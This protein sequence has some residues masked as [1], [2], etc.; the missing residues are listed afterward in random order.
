MIL[1]IFDFLVGQRPGEKEEGKEEEY[2][3]LLSIFF[4]CDTIVFIVVRRHA[5]WNRAGW[6]DQRRAPTT[7][8]RKRPLDGNPYLIETYWKDVNHFLFHFNFYLRRYQNFWYLLCL[9]FFFNTSS[10]CFARLYPRR[11][12]LVFSLTTCQWRHVKRMCILTTQACRNNNRVAKT[13]MNSSE[14]AL[15]VR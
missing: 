14:S 15:G 8:L 4:V 7:S 1:S 10:F 9:L 5:Y 6:L 12:C 3:L 13:C 11:V 2:Y